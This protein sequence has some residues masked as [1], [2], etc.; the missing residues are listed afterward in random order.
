MYPDSFLMAML[1][2]PASRLPFAQTFGSNLSALVKPVF[3]GMTLQ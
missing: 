1:G 2:V 3:E